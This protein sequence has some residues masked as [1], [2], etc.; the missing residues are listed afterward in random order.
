RLRGAHIAKVL[1]VG[2]L[3]DG[4]PFLVME[5]LEGHD[6]KHE[7][8]RRS[9]PIPIADAVGWVLQAC[10]GVAEAHANNII[11]RDLKRANLFL[12]HTG[13]GRPLIKV[14]AFGISKTIDRTLPENSL[15]LTNTTTILGSPVYM[16][17]EQMRSAKYVDERADVWALGV[18]LYEL[19]TRQ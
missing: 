15:A 2:R 9:E 3:E 5:Y 17:P 4:C 18:I 16:A 11:H 13:A 1:D 19:L 12:T 7:L 6:L 10:E 8:R 14:L